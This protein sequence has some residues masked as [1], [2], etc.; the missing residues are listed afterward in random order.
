MSAYWLFLSLVAIAYAAWLSFRA[1]RA[2]LRLPRKS[3]LAFLFFSAVATVVAQKPPA[4]MPRSLPVS[5]TVTDGDIERGYA[6]VET[7]EDVGCSFAMPTNATIVGNWHKRGTFGEWLR[8]ELGGFEFP[9]GTNGA[10]YS[11]FSVFN[12]GKIRPTPRDTVHEI[13]AVGVP[14]LAM[15]GASRFWTMDSDDGSKLLTWENFFLNADT[16]APVNAQ[17]RL[18]PGGDFTARS[19][20]VARQYR[21]IN[22]H[23]IDGDGLANEI[24]PMPRHCDGNF[25][26]TSPEW[27]EL[28]C[29]GIGNS[30]AYYFAEF[31]ATGSVG[32]ARIDVVCDGTSN[33]GDMTV[34][35]RSG[36]TAAFRFSSARTMRS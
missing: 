29:G 24:D 15:Q 18:C 11:S 27:R 26:G 31:S 4:H 30:N 2:L 36:Q 16:N 7:F 8:L 14:M 23:D 5:D 28:E 34:I 19:N 21:R 32:V 17:I 12:D 1:Y 3:I 35:A 13:S 6:L 25:F 33:L 22:A 20:E 9:M 10:L